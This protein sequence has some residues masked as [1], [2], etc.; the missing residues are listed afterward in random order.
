MC[1][2]DD[3]GQEVPAQPEEPSPWSRRM[4]RW[5]QWLETAGRLASLGLTIVLIVHGVRS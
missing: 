1:V 5:N 4:A 3:A 2:E